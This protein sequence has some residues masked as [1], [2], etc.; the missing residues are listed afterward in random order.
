[1]NEWGRFLAGARKRAGLTQQQ[2]ADKL[3]VERTAVTKWETQGRLPDVHHINAL[4]AALPV[5][6]ESLLEAMGV[7]LSS[8]PVTKLPPLLVRDLL[9]LPPEDLANVA[10][11]V[12]RLSRVVRSQGGPSQ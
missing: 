1:M 10:G 3:G 6:A 9:S 2:L 11:L 8:P 4:V 5:S 12:A 7:K